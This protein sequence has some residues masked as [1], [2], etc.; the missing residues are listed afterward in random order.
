MKRAASAET[1]PVTARDLLGASGLDAVL[2]PAGAVGRFG[3]GA[4][5]LGDY[6]DDVASTARLNA[7]ALQEKLAALGRSQADAAEAARA[8][9]AALKPEDAASYWLDAW[10]RGA[11]FLDILRQRGN[12]FVAHEAGAYRREDGSVI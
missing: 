10:Q 11:I 4:R 7:K 9:L 5:S 8:T 2:D 6:A 3:A 1:R 12:T